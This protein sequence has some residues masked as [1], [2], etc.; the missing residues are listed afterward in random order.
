MSLHLWLLVN[1]QT[2][3]KHLLVPGHLLAWSDVHNI[4]SHGTSSRELMCS[5]FKAHTCR[6]SVK[7]AS[8]LMCLNNRSS[9]H[10][11]IL[12]SWGIFCIWGKPSWQT[13]G[14][15]VE[16]MVIASPRFSPS[17]LIP[18][19]CC[20]VI[21]CLTLL[22]LQPNAPDFSTTMDCT[23]SNWEPKYIFLKLHS[24]GTLWQQQEV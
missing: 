24:S 8:E 2:A 20:D 1:Q 18:N 23:F 17:S 13:W 9:P 21:Y 12:E 5:S 3:L 16:T 10:G 7:C 6:L 15:G 19:H 11:A 14:I 22:L 4:E